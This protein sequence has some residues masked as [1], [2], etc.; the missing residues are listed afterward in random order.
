MPHNQEQEFDD[1][2][3]EKRWYDMIRWLETKTPTE[4]AGMKD[5]D[6]HVR[7]FLLTIKQGQDTRIIREMIEDERRK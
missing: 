5:I 6:P 2:A 7:Q 4:I 1:E 3:F